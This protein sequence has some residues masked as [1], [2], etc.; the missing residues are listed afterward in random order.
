MSKN[1]TLTEG[2]SVPRKT[3]RKSSQVQEATP[4][5]RIRKKKIFVSAKT[6]APARRSPE[7]PILCVLAKSPTLGQHTKVV[8]REIECKWFKELTELDLKAVYS[9]SKKKIVETIIKF[10]RKNL[11]VRG[12]VHPVSEENLG[13]SRATS[14]GIERALKEGGSWVPKYVEVHSMIEA[15]DDGETL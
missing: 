2:K 14:K 8:L 12:E 1:E 9:E 6:R 3:R 4:S 13:T 7:I 15:G 10:S 11:V 5:K